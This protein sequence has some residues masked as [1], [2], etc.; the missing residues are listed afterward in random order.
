M[1]EERL[2]V[3]QRIDDFEKFVGSKFDDNKEQHTTIMNKQDKTNGRVRSLE[4]W[5]SMIIG[6][7]IILNMIVVPIGIYILKE[8]LSNEII[9]TSACANSEKQLAKNLNY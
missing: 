6:G 3:I 2:A 8:I 5:R 9:T 1:S 7:L 4:M